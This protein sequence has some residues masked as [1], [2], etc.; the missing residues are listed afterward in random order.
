MSGIEQRRLL[1]A[2]EVAA[3]VGRLAGW[4]IVDGG[5]EK[6]FG[7]GAYLEGIEFVRRLAEVA[8][9]MDHHPDLSVGWRKVGVRLTTHSAKGVTRLDGELAEA[10]EKLFAQ[11]APG[12][13][14]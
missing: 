13:S 3:L 7:F 9:A 10:A 12:Y 14:V 8:E 2:D 5:L 6:V 11:S 4:E 1:R